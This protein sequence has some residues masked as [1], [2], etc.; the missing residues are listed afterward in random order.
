MFNANFGSNSAIS[1]RLLFL[2]VIYVTSF[3]FSLISTADLI[4]DLKKSIT[5]GLIKSTV[6]Q[7]LVK[8]NITEKCREK[9]HI[10]DKHIYAS[11]I[12][13]EKCLKGYP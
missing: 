9:A 12:D 11:F 5:F 3:W 4:A 10:V 6:I 7:F 1:W 13:Y 8:G 2:S